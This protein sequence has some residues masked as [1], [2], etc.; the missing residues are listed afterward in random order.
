MTNLRLCVS[1]GIFQQKFYTCHPESIPLNEWQT[2]MELLPEDK[3]LYVFPVVRQNK[4]EWLYRPDG[5]HSIKKWDFDNFFPEWKRIF[6]CHPNPDLK[7]VLI[8]KED[9]GQ[10]SCVDFLCQLREISVHCSGVKR[11]SSDFKFNIEVLNPKGYGT[12]SYPTYINIPL[13]DH[14]GKI[15]YTKELSSN[16]PMI[17]SAYFPK[18]QHLFRP[19][20]TD[21]TL[22][23]PKE[24]KDEICYVKFLINARSIGLFI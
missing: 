3:T 10:Y 20:L 21:P 22:Y 12:K 1:I 17:L 2:M 11:N 14:T 8:P 23:I 7:R 16:P 13:K 9:N 18:W 4:I 19:D 24:D 5:H 15:T 6:R